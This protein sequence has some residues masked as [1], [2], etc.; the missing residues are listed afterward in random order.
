MG[1]LCVQERKRT[2]KQKNVA[3]SNKSCVSD[4]DRLTRFLVLHRIVFFVLF[5]FCCWFVFFF[6]V[7]DIYIQICSN[8]DNKEKKEVRVPPRHSRSWIDVSK[9]PLVLSFSTYIYI[10]EWHRT[11]LQYVPACHYWCVCHQI[12]IYIRTCI[13]NSLCRIVDTV[14]TTDPT[15]QDVVVRRRTECKTW[16]CSIMIRCIQERERDKKKFRI[17]KRFKTHKLFQT[18]KKR[19]KL[20]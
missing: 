3:Y 1:W 15:V 14:R 16:T 7:V 13:L 18:T 6:S 17:K 20:V 19:R 5:L 10:R 9:Q 4:I 11:S 12:Y 8:I 2:N